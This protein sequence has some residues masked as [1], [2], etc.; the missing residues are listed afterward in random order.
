MDAAGGQPRALATAHKGAS[1]TERNVLAWAPSRLS[2]DAEI[3]P[4]LGALVS[5]SRDIDRNNGIA[6]S[7]FQTIIDNVLGSGLR[8]SPRPDYV[9]LGKTKSWADGWARET[10]ALWESYYWTTAC[11]AGDTLTG[12]GITTQ[13]ARAAML[14]GD[15]LA[16]P[17]WLPERR[18]GWSTKIQTIEADRLSNPYG[19]AERQ[20]FRGGIEFDAYGAPIAYHIRTTHPGDTVLVS[21]EAGFARWERIPRR[22]AHGRMKVLHVF[23]SKRSG[24]SRGKPL[25]T[26]VLPTFKNLDR[27][28]QAELQ[29]AVVNAMVAAV[30]TTP[31]GAEDIVE[32]YGQ[33][34]TA[35]LKAREEHAVRLQSGMLATL[36]PGDKLEPFIPSRPATAFDS[37]MTH[38]ERYIGLGYDL[39]YELLMK[40]FS[41]LNYVTARAMLAEAWRSFMRRRDWLTTAWIEP[42]YRLWLEEAVSAGK[43]DAPDYYATA[44]AWQRIRVIGPGRGTLDP[45]KEATAAQA[46][47]DAGLSTREDECAELGRDWVEV[48]EQ[49]A[50]E[51]A[52]YRELG[53]TAR[54]PDPAA[55][56]DQEPPMPERD[57]DARRVK[58]DDESDDEDGEAVSPD[59]NSVG[60]R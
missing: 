40:D 12:D 51:E 42:F 14:N 13:I 7:G 44:T 10:R 37:F 35:M 60:G 18:D 19:Q 56:G 58:D 15:A 23:D 4:E 52:R 26:S 21:D 1:Y 5:R 8:V 20:G 3:L 25:L 55:A 9:A 36:F 49:L 30:I 43:V 39:P 50:T 46:R 28:Q 22:A 11:H 53:L 54:A 17:L 29:A 31:L 2:V 57:D 6:E 38:L 32:L 47:I 59:D 45:V 27:Y 48:A 34:R 33:D 16:L 41:R 24:Q